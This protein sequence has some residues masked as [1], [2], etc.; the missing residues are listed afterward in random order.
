M[1]PPSDLA[2]IPAARAPVATL[3]F[4]SKVL[5]V[6]VGSLL[7]VLTGVVQLAVWACAF[8][9]TA[10]LEW[11]PIQ[12]LAFVFDGLAVLATLRFWRR[13]PSF[14]AAAVFVFAGNV[15]LFFLALLA[16][17]APGHFPEW[18]AR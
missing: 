11:D 4:L 6:A 16:R 13:G 15:S 14:C 8:R 2:P 9:V 17:N 7:A 5:K 3:R 1:R 12:L 18:L 10:N